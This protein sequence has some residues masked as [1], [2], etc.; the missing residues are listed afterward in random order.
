ME[1]LQL[2]VLSLLSIVVLSY[3]YF[4]LIKD[5]TTGYINHPFWF[6]MSPSIIKMLMVF[7]AFAI[8]GFLTTIISWIQYPPKEGIMYGN[9]LFYTISLFLLS[10]AIWPVATHYKIYFLSICSIILTAIASI[11]LLVGTVEE[12]KEDIKWYKV[13]G[14]LSLCL[15]TV[16]ADGVLWNANYIKQLH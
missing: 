10:A 9:N 7:Q 12:R 2:V 8:I 11:L 6:D 1:T 4:Y 3:Y 14:M 16:L 15:V 5:S 13:L